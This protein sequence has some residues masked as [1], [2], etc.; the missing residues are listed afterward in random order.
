LDDIY[1]QS[2]AN[3]DFTPQPYNGIN[4]LTAD[5][6][7]AQRFAV[8]GALNGKTITSVE[9]TLDSQVTTQTTNVRLLRYTPSTNTY[10]AF[11][12][13]IISIGDSF[14][15]LTTSETISQGD[16]IYCEVIQSG[17]NITGITVTLKI[18]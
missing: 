15:S 12:S 8:T 6:L 7:L 17:D 5:T 3:Y 16:L 18:E 1:S 10:S 13:D 14:A 11:A 2:A 4:T 9:Y